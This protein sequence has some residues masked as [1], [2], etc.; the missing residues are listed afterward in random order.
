M[1]YLGG[2]DGAS[3]EFL[4]L[5]PQVDEVLHSVENLRLDDEW[6]AVLDIVPE[7]NGVHR[8]AAR[9]TDLLRQAL[10]RREPLW[11]RERDLRGHQPGEVTRLET[12][13]PK[14]TENLVQAVSRYILAYALKTLRHC[15]IV[16]SIHDE[17]IIECGPGVSLQAVCD[18]M[19]R[20]PP[21]ISGL[22]LRADGYECQFYK[23]D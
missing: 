10:H 22:L 19:G 6:V 15:F 2:E 21:R 8:P 1:H 5:A 12:Y 3:A 13:G 16:G 9:Q 4:C 14:V 11:I 18:Q 7:R 23:K 17:L 20:T